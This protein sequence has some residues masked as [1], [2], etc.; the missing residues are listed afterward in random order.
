MTQSNPDFFDDP[1]NCTCLN[2]GGTT[3]FDN[4]WRNS[5]SC[6]DNRRLSIWIIFN[7]FFFI[8]VFFLWIKIRKEKESIKKDLRDFE[9]VP[10]NQAEER[11]T[12][13]VAE[14]RLERLNN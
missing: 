1:W 3:T 5:G 9:P 10:D 7:I 6:C 2:D 8:S 12:E 4:F 14:E 11:N 13:S